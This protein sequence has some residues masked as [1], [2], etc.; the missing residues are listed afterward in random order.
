[1]GKQEVTLL[2][3]LIFTL[4]Q[5]CTKT[6]VKMFKDINLRGQTKR[7]QMKDTQAN[8]I[9]QAGKLSQAVPGKYVLLDESDFMTIQNT[10]DKL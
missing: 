6:R 2:S 5:D 3:E 9:F 8:H 10:R 4:W 1:M 7:P